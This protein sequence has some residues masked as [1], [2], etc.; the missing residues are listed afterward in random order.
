M[1]NILFWVIL[2]LI[3][4]TYKY[5]LEY[6]KERKIA[7]IIKE[8]QII[9]NSTEDSL[10]HLLSIHGARFIPYAMTQ[11]FL[12]TGNYKSPVCIQGKNFFGIRYNSRSFNYKKHLNH[13]AYKSMELSV[14]DYVAWQN[15]MIKS[16]EAFYKKKVVTDE[17]YEF[18]LEHVVIGKNV[19]R[20][21]ED[22]NYISKLRKI[23]KMRW[24]KKISSP[25]K[26]DSPDQIIAFNNGEK[27][28]Q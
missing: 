28:S 26:I 4:V 24:D 8:N 17:D 16:H 9:G 14:K 5:P 18:L 3:G 25:F 22:P 10:Y 13:A 21:A 19:Y 27:N 12:E 1:R 7:A 2:G 23:K 11:S 20:Y 15:R 6:Y